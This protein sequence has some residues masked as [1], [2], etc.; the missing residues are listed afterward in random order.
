MREKTSEQPQPAP[1]VSAEGPCPTIIQISRTP[2]AVPIYI[3]VNKKYQTSKILV[4]YVYP[5]IVNF[6][7][8]WERKIL[9]TILIFL[10]DM[11]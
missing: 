6:L 3:F 8:P 4:F 10:F 2:Q 9:I 1:T 11:C 5:L 7:F